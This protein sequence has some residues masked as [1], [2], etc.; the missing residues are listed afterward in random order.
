MAYLTERER[1]I[2]E[3]LKKRKSVQ[4]IGTYYK[5]SDSSVSRSITNIQRKVKDIEE[6]IEFLIDIGFMQI[7]GSKVDFI[8]RSRDPKALGR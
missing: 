6:D 8:S 3:L 4:N 2:M 7:R 5:V 1:E